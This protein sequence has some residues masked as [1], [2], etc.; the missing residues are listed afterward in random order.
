VRTDLYQGNLAIRIPVGSTGTIED[1][2]NTLGLPELVPVLNNVPRASSLASGLQKQDSFK[3]LPKY[4]VTN[5]LFEDYVRNVIGSD[6][7]RSA[8]VELQIIDF[9]NCMYLLDSQPLLGN[10]ETLLTSIAYRGHSPTPLPET[11]P[12]VQ[13][14][15]IFASKLSLAVIK[16]G[17]IQSDI[18]SAA[19][20][21]C[22][23]LFL[24][25]LLTR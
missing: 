7:L 15:E 20:T 23:K 6:A 2:L 17:G 4:L 12:R 3:H 21:V 10:M 9:S 14:P 5:S 18:W 16:C 8:D 13:A 25:R 11:F 22:L 1:L 19:C 24:L